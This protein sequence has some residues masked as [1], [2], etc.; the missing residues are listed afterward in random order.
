[1]CAHLGMVTGHGLAGAV[2]RFYPRWIL[3]TACAFLLIA[4]IINIGADLGEWPKPPLTLA[5][6]LYTNSTSAILSAGQVTLDAQGNPDATWIFRMGSTLTT[7]AGTQIV[8][9]GGAKAANIYWQV[10]TSATLG[11]TSVFKGNI[12]AG[13]S[14]SANTGAVV[15]GRLLTQ[16][17]AVSL[18]SNVVTV[19]TP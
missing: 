13:I 12:L 8:L 10:G 5:P 7:I 18:L 2:R 11:T 15:E 16:T 17:G 3:W 6:G 19:P 1:M 9:A 4:N 14:I